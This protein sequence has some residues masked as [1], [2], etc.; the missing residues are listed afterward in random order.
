MEIVRTIKMIIRND[1]F[2]LIRQLEKDNFQWNF[3]ENTY[4]Q[5]K[6]QCYANVALTFPS[7]IIDSINSDDN[8]Y[9]HI[10]IN[11]LGLTGADSPLPHYW[12][13]VANENSDQTEK[14][15]AF[16]NMFQ[17]RIYYL[18][19]L[20]WKKHQVIIQHE[21]NNSPFFN[22]LQALSG[23]ALHAESQ[24]EFACAG[25]FGQRVHNAHSLLS[26][27][28]HI[29][30]GMI[31]SIKQFVPKWVQ[32][33]QTHRLSHN[34]NECLI[35]SNNSLLGQRILSACHCITIEFGSIQLQDII[36]ILR[37][38]VMITHMFNVI[39]KYTGLIYQVELILHLFID[40]GAALYF[41]M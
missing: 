26:I 7:Q 20:S 25:L 19:Y 31:I 37:N 22:Y 24:Q 35:L 13:T 21:Q 10:F 3:Y 40:R 30:Q 29:N 12:L 27:L 16:L 38:Q 41:I 34:H 4:S 1:F 15:S 28:N 5:Y 11:F 14:I 36:F 2:Q 33:N 18:Y 17:Q 32:L 39:K 8:G 9:I 6:I 23:G